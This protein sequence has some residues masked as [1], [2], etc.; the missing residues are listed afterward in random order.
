MEGI[1]PSSVERTDTDAYLD[2]DKDPV[3]AENCLDSLCCLPVRME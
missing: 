2:E 3:K 1:D